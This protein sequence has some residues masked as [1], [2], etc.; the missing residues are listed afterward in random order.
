MEPTTNATVNGLEGNYV[1]PKDWEEITAA[2]KIERLREVIKN[3]N[4]SI[5][6]MQS[7]VHYIREAFKKHSHTEKEVV[8][9][10]NEYGNNDGSIGIGAQLT[11]AKY[12]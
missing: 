12:F 7:S 6:R 11:N 8:I 9:P 5:A 3:L 10:F 2:E 1:P 4:D